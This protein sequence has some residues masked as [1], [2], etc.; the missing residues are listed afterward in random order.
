[1]FCLSNWNLTLA[2]PQRNLT[3]SHAAVIRA[4]LNAAIT[5]KVRNAGCKRSMAEGW[6]MAGLGRTRLGA[7][8]SF[9]ISEQKD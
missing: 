5:I 1:M 9:V 6:P 8:N 3:L 2:Q 4:S 7:V